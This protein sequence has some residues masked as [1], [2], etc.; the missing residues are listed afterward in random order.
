MSP[1]RPALPAALRRLLVLAMQDSPG[2]EICGLLVAHNEQLSFRRL[3]NL[4]GPGEFWVEEYALEAQL[5]HLAA[6]GGRVLGLVHSH[7]SGLELSG[8]DAAA[9]PAS[10]WPWLVVVPQAADGLVGCWYWAEGP[11]IHAEALALAA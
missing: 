1:A 11:H 4:G 10:R 2:R 5:R 8:P 3:P 9:L 6:T 7:C